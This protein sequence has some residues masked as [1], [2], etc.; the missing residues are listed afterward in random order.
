M[1]RAGAGARVRSAR[2]VVGVST[3]PLISGWGVLL[4]S[5]L[6]AAS[7]TPSLVPRA[8]LMQ[9]LIGGTV[10]AIGYG[11][12]VAALA[13]W[14]WMELPEPERRYTVP[15]AVAAALAGAGVV[16]YGL[17]RTDEWQNGIRAVMGMPPVESEHTLKVLGVAAGAAAVLF[18]VAWLLKVLVRVVA[19]RL[20]RVV[21]PRLALFA[22]LVTAFAVFGALL[23]GVLVR[24]TLAVLDASYAQLDQ[25]VDPDTEEPVDPSRTG[26]EASLVPWSSL[27]RD[28]RNFLT[29]L[30][31]RE[32]LRA[33]WNGPAKEP[34]RVYVG[35]NSA[36]DAQARAEL[37]LA[38]LQRVNAF[39]RDVLVVAIP[40]GTGFLDDGAVDALEYLHKGDVATVAV[41]YSYLQSPFSLIFEAEYGAETARALLSAVYGYWTGLPRDGRPL[42][43]L[44]GL[45][46]GTFNSELSVRIH[47]LIGDPVSG[48]LWAG[49]PFPSPIHREFTQ[50]RV[51]GSP[52]WLPRF[53]DGSLVRF[54]NQEEVTDAG[55][56]WGPVRVLYMQHASDPIVFFDVAMLWRKPDW[57]KQPRGPDV[58]PQMRWFPVVT[59]FQ[60]AA[61]MALSN[62]VPRGYGHQYAAARY[63]DAWTLLTDPGISGDDAER[64]KA[65]LDG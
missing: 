34:L 25:L 55:A 31:T 38:E 27:G 51:A 50:G 9:G 40:T 20:H 13:L 7:L 16:A 11:I 3:R 41:Q 26:S 60:V 28:G 54:I 2:R 57:L 47:E 58:S 56:S 19:R 5:L 30:T 53:A 35:L 22:G 21:P 43:F 17:S 29:G 49:P 62:S 1:Q 63:V 48:A 4:G 24:Y 14:R 18:L 37:A 59:A 52:Q 12:A 65:H 23:D 33:F 45:S 15:W 39:E 44:Y 46:L 32:D 64:L 36:D 10:F 8:P 61:D 42:L 6:L